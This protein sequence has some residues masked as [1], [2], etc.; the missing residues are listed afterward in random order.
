MG[1]WDTTRMCRDFL[2]SREATADRCREMGLV[3]GKEKN[4]P[5]KKCGRPMRWDEPPDQRFGR[6]RC[7]HRNCLDRNKAFKCSADSWFE[8]V[9]FPTDQ[10]MAHM[11]SFACKMTYKIA[12]NE[13]KLSSSTPS[14]Q[15]IAE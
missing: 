8:H 5:F 4:C 2:N 12:I 6:L 3:G 11:Y 15:T 9:K 13:C 1:T 10:A 14:A 7:N